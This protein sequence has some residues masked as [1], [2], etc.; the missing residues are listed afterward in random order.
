MISN[1]TK[2]YT[3]ITNERVMAFSTLIFCYTKRP[4]D[5]NKVTLI[6]K[7]IQI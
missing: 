7:D 4:E 1:S 5:Q 6:P 3:V 2:Q